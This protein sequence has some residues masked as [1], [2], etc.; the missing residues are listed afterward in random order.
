MHGSGKT[1][2]VRVVKVNNPS[3]NVVVSHKVLL[4]EQIQEQRQRILSMLERGL[5]ARRSRQGNCGLWC[6]H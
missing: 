1:L 3:E 4:E 2:D 5:G 6:L